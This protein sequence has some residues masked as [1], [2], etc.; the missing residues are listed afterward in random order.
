MLAAR[1]AEAASAAVREGVEA[2]AVAC[3]VVAVGAD[4]AAGEERRE[5]GRGLISLSVRMGRGAVRMPEGDVAFVRGLVKDAPS[6]AD[7]TF[8]TILSGAACLPAPPSF[9]PPSPPPAPPSSSSSSSDSS[10]S[11][12]M[13]SSSNNAPSPSPPP[14]SAP[15]SPPT[16]RSSQSSSP[17]VRGCK[18]RLVSHFRSQT[19]LEQ[20]HAPSSAS[21]S[22]SA[23]SLPSRSP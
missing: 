11:S 18:Q 16:G 7:A 14:P 2:A 17:S 5:V 15:A 21:T 23:R 9:L 20:Q 12:S 6:R 22:S 3:A 19:K 13:L 8:S 1:E 10:S 4:A